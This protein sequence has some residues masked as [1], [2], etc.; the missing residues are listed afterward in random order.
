MSSNC[1][2]PYIILRNRLPFL[3]QCPYH[4]QAQQCLK[5]TRQFASGFAGHVQ[6]CG[7]QSIVRQ[8]RYWTQKPKTSSAPSN[9]SSTERSPAKRAITI[10]VSKRNLPLIPVH[11]LTLCF[12]SPSH[13]LQI[14]VP[15]CSGE[16]K[17]LLSGHPF[18]SIQCSYKLQHMSLE[19][20][21]EIVKLFNNLRL[22]RWVGHWHHPLFGTQRYLLLFLSFILLLV[23]KY[24]KHPQLQASGFYLPRINEFRL[25][26]SR[27]TFFRFSLPSTASS[28][29]Q[30]WLLSSSP[31]SLPQH[32]L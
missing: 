14:T 15:N 28:L 7:H 5:Q 21:W 13:C 3:L 29:P 27:R 24:K 9:C 23:P 19:F 17:Q 25:W 20:C 8:E 26:T 30:N 16:M 6:T 12:D 31:F 22:D 1:G 2:N 11:S 10:L 18:W 4:W 32:Y